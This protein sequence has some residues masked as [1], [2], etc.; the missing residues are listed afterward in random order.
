MLDKDDQTSALPK[1]DQEKQK[2]AKQIWDKVKKKGG[3]GGSSPTNLTISATAT[4]SGSI[5]GVPIYDQSL[6]AYP[7]SACG[8]TSGAMVLG[9]WDTHGYTRLQ[10]DSDRTNGIQLMNDLYVDMGT[11]QTGTDKRQ[12]RN[13]IETHA[14][15]QNGYRFSTAQYDNL[16]G[17]STVWYYV[18]YEID[19]V[20]P[21]GF[22]IGFDNGKVPG[23]T[24]RY[25]WVTGKG[26]SDGGSGNRYVTINNSWG[27]TD[28][29]S[30]D[31]YWLGR[32]DI[33]VTAVR[34]GV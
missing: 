9:Y 16:S 6:S 1:L 27:G 18:K 12:W 19:N 3:Y 31:N 8:P 5:S 30:F 11:G 2:E 34:P 14:N 22:Y 13:G 33:A 4:T 26:Y 17:Y 32:D 28:S 15:T 21:F 10:N 23:L 24:Y 20:R 29:I 25:H 7:D